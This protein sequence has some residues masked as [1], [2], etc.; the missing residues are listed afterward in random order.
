MAEACA[1]GAVVGRPRGPAF[2]RRRLEALHAGGAPAGGTD[3]H[4]DNARAIAAYRK[5]GFRVTGGPVD[6]PWGRSVLMRRDRIRQAPLA[7]GPRGG[8]NAPIPVG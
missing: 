5:A 8:S 7:V 1:Y 2:I 3:P 6:T 4:P